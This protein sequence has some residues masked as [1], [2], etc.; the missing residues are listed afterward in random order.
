MLQNYF[1]DTIRNVGPGSIE[2]HPLW[3]V[4]EEYDQFLAA[5][6]VGCVTA[7]EVHDW[8]VATGKIEDY[9]ADDSDGDL[10]RRLA[11]WDT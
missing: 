6:S 9:L 3:W 7:A 8:P 1:F 4:M 2:T 5:H 10:E 11:E